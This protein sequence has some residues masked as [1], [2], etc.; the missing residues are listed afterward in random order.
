MQILWKFKPEHVTALLNTLKRL[1]SPASKSLQWLYRFP[2]AGAASSPHHLSHPFHSAFSHPGFL[3]ARH[4]LS[5]SFFTIGFSHWN[6]LPLEHMHDSESNV[7]LVNLSLT[8][9]FK[10]SVFHPCIVSPGGSAVYF[11][12]K[13]NNLDHTV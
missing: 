12:I 6:A 1:P 10:I 13:L 11:S 7:F 2:W 3:H 8:T 4:T 9:Y 5:Q